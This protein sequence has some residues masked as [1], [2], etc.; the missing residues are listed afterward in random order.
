MVA[1]VAFNMLVN[2]CLWAKGLYS[3]LF[4]HKLFPF[5]RK[6]LKKIREMRKKKAQPSPAV[7]IKTI[8]SKNY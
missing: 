1:I 2:V 6:L 8:Q 5:L 7:G 3:E 4:C